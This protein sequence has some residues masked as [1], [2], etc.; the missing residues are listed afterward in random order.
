MNKINWSDHLVNLVVVIL[1]IS[2]AF[3]LGA[4]AEGNK[5]RKIEN[6]I[7][8][9]IRSNLVTDTT[10]MHENMAEIR[11]ILRCNDKLL[12]EFEEIPTDSLPYYL[13]AAGRRIR[14]YKNTTG[15]QRL[16]QRGDLSSFNNQ[17]LVSD[18]I[19]AYNNSYKKVDEW[20]EEEKQYTE[21]VEQFYLNNV[22]AHMI[23]GDNE[24]TSEDYSELSFALQSFTFKNIIIANQLAKRQL[25]SSIVEIKE[26]FKELIVQ[27]D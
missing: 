22:P 9:E 24:I 11:L 5:E 14:F 19:Y 3:W 4:W 21:M 26:E 18:I 10:M 27:L 20:L 8:D 15:F 1:G 7:L 2:I 23:T 6:A 17:Y 25:L 16:V 13:F 12:N